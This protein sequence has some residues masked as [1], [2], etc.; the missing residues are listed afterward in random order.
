MST[1]CMV[2]YE[3]VTE[4]DLSKNEEWYI[5]LNCSHRF[6]YECIKQSMIA[7]NNNECPYCRK[8][9]KCIKKR[10][11]EIIKGKRCS[12]KAIYDKYCAVHK[13][14]TVVDDSHDNSDDITSELAHPLENNDN[15]PTGDD[16]KPTEDDNKFDDV[17]VKLPTY[18]TE[19]EQIQ[20]ALAESYNMFNF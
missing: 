1:T 8:K 3:T 6:H 20:M 18:F 11:T 14:Y 7:S 12:R 5:K 16:N 13:K 4:K 15:K 2:C 19:E 9:I 10:C 17:Y